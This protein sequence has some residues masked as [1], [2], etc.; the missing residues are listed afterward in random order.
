LTI[1]LIDRG[2]V[3]GE[4][5]NEKS[6]PRD[7]ALPVAGNISLKA[8]GLQPLPAQRLLQALGAINTMTRKTRN[9]CWYPILPIPTFYKHSPRMMTQPLCITSILGFS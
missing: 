7:T 8:G 2:L 6:E 3:L 5:V 1:T 9:F 4:A